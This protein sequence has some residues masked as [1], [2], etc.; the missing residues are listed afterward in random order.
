MAR[1]V[2]AMLSKDEEYR[3]SA[4]VSG[5]LRHRVFRLHA[6]FTGH[7]CSPIMARATSWPTSL[8]ARQ[9]KDAAYSRRPKS[10]GGDCGRLKMLPPGAVDRGH[11][12]RPTSPGSTS[13]DKPSRPAASCERSPCP[14]RR[15]VRQRVPTDPEDDRSRPSQ[16]PRTDHPIY[17]RIWHSEDERFFVSW[18]EPGET[19]ITHH[20]PFDDPNQTAARAAGLAPA[21]CDVYFTPAT[22]K[23]GSTRR[24]ATAV[25]PP[26]VSGSISTRLPPLTGSDAR[27]SRQ[28][29]QRPRHSHLRRRPHRQRLPYVQARAAGA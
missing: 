11:W 27:R 20:E 12:A 15:S 28:V 25:R 3:G 18:R 1:S 8:M 22:F 6:S 21:G 19:E 16:R 23:P 9:Q 24:R 17:L 26:T 14:I 10:I 13:G 7:V 4:L 2:W 29:R 5:R